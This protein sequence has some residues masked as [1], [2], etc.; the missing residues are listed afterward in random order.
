[1]Y[2]R[3]QVRAVNMLTG[4]STQSAV[5]PKSQFGEGLTV[6][7]DHLVQLTWREKVILEYDKSTLALL[8]TVPYPREG[9]GLAADSSR[10]VMYA[11]DGSAALHTLDP[12]TYRTLRSI[13]IVDPKLGLEPVPIYGLNE[14]EVVGTEVWANVYPM[15]Y[16]KWSNCIARINPDSGHVIGWVDLTDLVHD[17]SSRVQRSPANFVLNGIAVHPMDMGTSD[18][19]ERSIFVTGKEW[20]WL[21]E[22]RVTP[23]LGKDVDHVRRHCGLHLESSIKKHPYQPK[24]KRT[25]HG[26]SQQQRES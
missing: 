26:Q 11:T 18:I 10:K 5:M 24:N 17:Q 8:R 22:I 9:W 7:G 13:T 2:G 3:S 15:Q 4:Q 21:Y 12:L 14:L 19:T 20:D 23:A 16:H 25:F 6:Y 1:M